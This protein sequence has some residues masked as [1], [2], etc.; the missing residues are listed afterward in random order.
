MKVRQRTLQAG[1]KGTVQVG[2]EYEIPD[3]DFDEDVHERLEPE[4]DLKAEAEAKAE[5]PDRETATSAP[6]ETAAAKTPKRG[7]G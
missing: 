5:S 3:Q 6:K 7:K 1:P 2:T 4:R